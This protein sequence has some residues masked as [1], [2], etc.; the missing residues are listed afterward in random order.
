MLH[1]YKKKNK[2]RQRYNAST[3]TGSAHVAI[4]GGTLGRRAIGRRFSPCLFSVNMKG[5]RDHGHWFVVLSLA[6]NNWNGTS[7]SCQYIISGTRDDDQK[8][9][10][11]RHRREREATRCNEMTGP[12]REKQKKAAQIHMRNR[13]E[14]Q[15]ESAQR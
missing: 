15:R 6:E 1:V 10:V 5:Y 2:N 4:V 12:E 11:A 7:R 8:S 3:S 9:E 14:A 13:R